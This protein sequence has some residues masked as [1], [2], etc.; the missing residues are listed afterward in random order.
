[1]YS[2]VVSKT[3]KRSSFT[4]MLYTK[5]RFITEIRYFILLL[6]PAFFSAGIWWSRGF[7]SINKIRFDPPGIWRHNYVTWLSIVSRAGHKRDQCLDNLTPF[8]VQNMLAC[9]YTW[10]FFTAHR[11]LG[12]FKLV[13]SEICRPSERTLGRLLTKIWIRYGRHST[14]TPSCVETPFWLREAN[15]FFVFFSQKP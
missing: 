11:D 12:F 3:H 8:Q 6:I 15:T 13:N 5:I 9:H 1:M 2:C 10:P 4:T 14:T 7:T